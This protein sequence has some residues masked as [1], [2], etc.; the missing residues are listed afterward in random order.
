MICPKCNSKTYVKNSIVKNEFVL[1]YRVC[2]KCKYQ[3]K[4]NERMY[5]G[6]D[7]RRILLDIKNT[8]REIN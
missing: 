8:L 2:S 4:T 6:W 7:Y 1:R 5:T 3:F